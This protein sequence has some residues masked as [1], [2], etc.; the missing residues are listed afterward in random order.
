MAQAAP[1][2]GTGNCGRAIVAC[3]PHRSTSL[4]HP[5][6]CSK[7]CPPPTTTSPPR[8]RHLLQAAKPFARYA[9]DAERD[10][11]LRGRAHWGDPMAG[12]AGGKRSRWEPEDLTAKYQGSALHKSGFIIPQEVRPQPACLPGSHWPEEASKAC[13]CASRAPAACGPAWRVRTGGTCQQPPHGGCVLGAHASSRHSTQSAA[14]AGSL[15]WQRVHTPGHMRAI[16]RCSARR[17]M[18][19]LCAAIS[20]IQFQRARRVQADSEPPGAGRQ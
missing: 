11:E 7:H 20:W 10:A 13:C 17:L 5:T 2:C 1:C 19:Q 18:Q 14:R 3:E 16:V 12:K 9:D 6:A 15:Y 4:A 8:P